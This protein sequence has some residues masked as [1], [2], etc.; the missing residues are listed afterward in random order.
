MI[1]PETASCFDS[2]YSSRK[3]TVIKPFLPIIVLPAQRDTFKF[4]SLENGLALHNGLYGFN[5]LILDNVFY[6]KTILVREERR[7]HMA[8]KKKNLRLGQQV[9]LSN[10]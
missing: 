2:S 10:Y 4:V 7:Q 5:V 6:F 3:D 1:P 8:L 9:H